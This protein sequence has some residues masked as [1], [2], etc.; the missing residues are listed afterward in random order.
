MTWFK[1][2]LTGRILRYLTVERGELLL[3]VCMY[4]H[5]LIAFSFLGAFHSIDISLSF[6]NE[7]IIFLHRNVILYGN[8][9]T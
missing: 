5:L 7:S 3:L 6:F 8:L 1:T 2:V 4:V 9:C